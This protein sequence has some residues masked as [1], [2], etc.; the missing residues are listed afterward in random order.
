MA[1]FVL[2][3]LGCFF[4]AKL[5]SFAGCVLIRKNQEKKGKKCEKTEEKG[6]Y[7]VPLTQRVTFKAILT[8]N[9]QLQVPKIV[10]QQ[11]KLETTETLKVTVNVVGILGAKENFFAKM[12]PD[13]RILVPKVP[14]AQLR[15]NEP[16]IVGFPLEVT[17][18]PA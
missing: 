4:E 12:Y 17:L 6:R 5:K 13:G 1:G 10:R 14:L 15:R 8:K 16:S 2:S 11:F 7:K 3:V 9:N 18:E